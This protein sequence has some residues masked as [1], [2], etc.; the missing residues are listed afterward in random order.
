MRIGLPRRIRGRTPQLNLFLST[1]HPAMIARLRDS[2]ASMRRDIYGSAHILFAS[3][4]RSSG[5]ASA[6][7]SGS[8]SVGRYG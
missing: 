7:F 1:L 4:A 8:I 3:A 6:H 2:G 5:D